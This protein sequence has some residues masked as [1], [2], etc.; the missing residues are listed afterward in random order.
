MSVPRVRVSA[1]SIKQLLTCSMSY[2]YARVLKLPEKVWPRTVMGSL[3]HSIFESLRRARHRHHYDTITAPGTSVDYALSPA[4]ARLV[5]MWID[6][7]NIAPEL[8]A[9]LNGMLYVGL[10]LVDFHW[11][12]AD[13]DE[14]GVPKTHGPEHEFTLTLPDGTVIKGFIDDMGEEGDIMVI[15]DFKSQRNRFTASELPHSIQAHIYQLYVW[16]RFN[17]LARVEFVLLRHPPT[18]RTKTKH[19]QIVP[20]ASPAHLE[21]LVHYIQGV[22]AQVNQ[23]GMED[24][25]SN[26]C[27]D[28]GWCR[29]VCSH[30]AP[31]DYWALVKR[32]D[33][34]QVQIKAFMLD[35]EPKEIAA[36]EIL[37]K[38]HHSG[39]LSAWRG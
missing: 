1:S 38:R 30:Y 33:P 3:C 22:S 35:N 7:H 34:E 18:S 29:N 36:D 9:D 5:R 28:Q 12:G 8:I 16:T 11:T 17:K 26:V 2:Y 19:L 6:K 21:G 32:D 14:V 15:R 13:K 10:L 31:H 39:C 24:A 27:T 37:V 20:P 4:I 25:W 23:F